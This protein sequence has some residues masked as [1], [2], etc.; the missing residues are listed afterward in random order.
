MF[1]CAKSRRKN[2]DKI[3]GMASWLILGGVLPL[4]VAL[5]TD[6]QR[7]YSFA[8]LYNG[9]ALSLSLGDRHGY[10][11][12]AGKTCKRSLAA[13]R[14]AGCCGICNGSENER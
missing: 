7:S 3:E 1:I 5:V 11:L 4:C 9:G 8:L 10:R 12:P 2:A 14:G 6:H 13:D